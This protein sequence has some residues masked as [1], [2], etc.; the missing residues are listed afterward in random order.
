MTISFPD[1]LTYPT[2][3][4]DPSET[5]QV[6]NPATGELLATIASSSVQST[7]DGSSYSVIHCLNQGLKPIHNLQ[8][9]ILTSPAILASHHAFQTDWRHRPALER[10]T[11]LF[12]IAD[13]LEKHKEELAEILCLE[14]GKPYQD[15]LMFDVRFCIEIFKYYAGV[16]GKLPGECYEVG[17]VYVMVHREAFGLVL[18][19]VEF[20]ESWSSL[21]MVLGVSV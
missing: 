12:K 4:S 5:F 13:A 15:A 21:R 18:Y 9:L 16:L 2:S 7:T 19:L 11:F 14:N 17:G 10:A 20:L 3:S 6:H 8:N 1:L